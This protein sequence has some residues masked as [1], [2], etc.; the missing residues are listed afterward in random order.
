[1]LIASG[2]EVVKISGAGMPKQPHSLEQDQEADLPALASY[3]A[4]EAISGL[5]LCSD[6]LREEVQ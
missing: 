5:R 3:L 4:P 2:S 1:M 6:G